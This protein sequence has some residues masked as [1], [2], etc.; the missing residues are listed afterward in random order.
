VLQSPETSLGSVCELVAEIPHDGKTLA[1]PLARQPCW[2]NIQ[3]QAQ[4]PAL[5]LHLWQVV[6]GH[7]WYAIYINSMSDK[8]SC[9]FEF[10]R[11][12]MP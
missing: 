2:P 5:A 1:P 9:A 7:A 6:D 11:V 12:T 3:I 4:P 10:T 8:L